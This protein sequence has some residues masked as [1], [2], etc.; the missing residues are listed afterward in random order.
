[1]NLEVIYPS[2]VNVIP[3]GQA[4][5]VFHGT[6]EYDEAGNII[7]EDQS[8]GRVLAGMIK[9]INQNV[10]SKYTIQ[11]PPVTKLPKNKELS[12]LQPKYLGMIS[13]LQSEFGL[14]DSQGVADYHQKW[15][16]QF[17]EKNASELDAQHKIGLVKRWAFGDKGFRIKD[18]ED[19]KL[20]SWAEGVDKGDQQKISKENL[21]KFEKIFLGV[22]AEVLSFMSSVLTANP[23]SAKRAMVARLEQTIKDVEAKGDEKQVQKLKLELQRLQDLGGFEKIVPNE[24]I[25]FVYGGN[26]MKLT[27][28]FAPLNQILG[29]FFGG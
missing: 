21:M 14:K 13:G 9:Q 12:K 2:S 5:L 27:G 17:V 26:T 29:I 8:A 24:G 16:E 19:E 25:V 7:G 10:Q 6:F 4:L 20:R 23:D 1:M 11:G 3:Y 28:A 15:W 22:G 18:I